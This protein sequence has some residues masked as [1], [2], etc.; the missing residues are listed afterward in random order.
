M[1]QF[2]GYFSL[3]L[4][5]IPVFYSLNILYLAQITPNDFTSR[6]K[7]HQTHQ[8]NPPNSQQAPLEP[9]RT[10]KGPHKSSIFYLYI[11]MKL[12]SLCSKI[13][14]NKIKHFTVYPVW[15]LSW[16]NL[17]KSLAPMFIHIIIRITFA[18]SFL[19][20]LTWFRVIF[21]QN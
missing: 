12:R 18:S 21:T 11:N 2:E 17:K 16:N 3:N 20:N 13:L 4:I 5:F 14:K 9:L 10:P 8:K 6:K 15:F 19:S 1:W 7:L